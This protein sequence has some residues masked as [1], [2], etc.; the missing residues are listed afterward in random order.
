MTRYE[1]IGRTYTRTRRTDPRIAARIHAALGPARTVVNVGAGI[2]SYEPA[3]RIVVAVDPSPTMLSQ[4]AAAAAPAVRAVAERLP[5]RDSAFDV[6]L[7]VLT[8]HHWDDLAAGLSEMRRVAPRQ[9]VYFFE[10]SFAPDFWLVRDYLPNVVDLV[11]TERN[12]P[13]SRDFERHLDVRTVEPVPVPADCVDGFGACYWNRPEAYLDAN[14]QAGMSTFAQLDPATR[15]D[16][17]ERLHADLESGAWDARHGHL[18]ARSEYDAG[19]R[20]ITAG[21]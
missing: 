10:P 6:A 3:D 15:A 20:V 14:V 4:R 8:A 9:V 11:A 2:G 12:A 7:A 19:Y 17:T 21:S 18:R 1:T 16:V 5:F 13:S